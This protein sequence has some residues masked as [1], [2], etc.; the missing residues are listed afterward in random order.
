MIRPYLSDPDV[1]PKLCECCCG[2]PA[3]IATYSHAARGWVKGQPKRFISGH[4]GRRVRK[5]ERYEVR[6]CGF[7]TPCWVW[8]LLKDARGY[9]RVNPRG[10][11]SP[12]LAHRFYFRERF[13]YLPPI[14]HHLCDN[15]SCVNPEHMLALE[16]HGDHH[17]VEQADRTHCRRGHAY[18]EHGRFHGNGNGRYCRACER[19]NERKRAAVSR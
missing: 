5:P 6:D 7:E 19:E 13:G 9:G 16:T 10:E 1:T 8:L 11:R 4:N 2:E 17:A 12:M 14:L 15:T 3:P 18:A